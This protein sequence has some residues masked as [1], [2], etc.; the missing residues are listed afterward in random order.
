[1]RWGGGL[2][3]SSQKR[4]RAT[5]KPVRAPCLQECSEKLGRLKLTCEQQARQVLSACEQAPQDVVDLDFDPRTPFSVCVATLKPI[6]QGSSSVLCTYCGARAVPEQEGN[7]CGNCGL[8]KF[9]KQSSGLLVSRA[10][11]KDMK[12]MAYR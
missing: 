1:M 9:G 3:H 11:M 2:K 5:P 10:Q 12:K 4:R 6:Y 8:A 7:L